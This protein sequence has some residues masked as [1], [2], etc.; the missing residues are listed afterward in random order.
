MSDIWIK[1]TTGTSSTAW[2]R[3]VSLFVKTTTGTTSAAWKAVTNV[4]VYFN[5]G[6]TR[7]WPLSGIFNIT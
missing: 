4:Y 3:A 2:E 6:W 5:S 1:E 7:V